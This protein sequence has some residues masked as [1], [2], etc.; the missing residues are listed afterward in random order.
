MT[1]VALYAASQF[2][3]LIG[4]PES[5]LRW[6]LPA[7]IVVAAIAGVVAAVSLKNRSPEMYAQMGRH[8]DIDMVPDT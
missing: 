5:P 7:L 4:N 8:R 6:I 3:L 1:A 2:G